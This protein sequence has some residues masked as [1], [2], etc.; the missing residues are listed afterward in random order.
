MKKTNYKRYVPKGFNWNLVLVVVIVVFFNKIL[1]FLKGS[2]DD[3]SAELDE[4]NSVL[5]SSSAQSLADA[6][7][8]SMS[9]F[10]GGDYERIL[11][12]F[13]EIKTTSNYNKVFNSFGTR[14]YIP[15]LRVGKTIGN[16]SRLN[17]NQWLHSE[18]NSEQVA[19]LSDSY[20]FFY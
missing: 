13:D 12:L 14:G 4:S 16:F 19:N 1:N 8:L 10:G 11:S 3:Y 5:S 2:S 9:G 17:L 18:L 15:G 7:H 6:L 20:T